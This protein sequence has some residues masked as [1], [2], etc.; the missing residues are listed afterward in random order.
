MYRLQHLKVAP[1]LMDLGAMDKLTYQIVDILI[2]STGAAL[3]FIG[4]GG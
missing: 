3:V 4:A 2:R 1:Q